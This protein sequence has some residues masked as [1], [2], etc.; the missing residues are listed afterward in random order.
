M[1]SHKWGGFFLFFCYVTIRLK[2]SYF[3]SPP[4]RVTKAYS[5]LSGAYTLV[6]Q[7]SAQ[8]KGTGLK[9]HMDPCRW[10][11]LWARMKPDCRASDFNIT[12]Q[13]KLRNGLEKHNEQYAGQ[14]HK[15]WHAIFTRWLA[16][17]ILYYLARVRIWILRCPDEHTAFFSN[18]SIKGKMA[19]Y[20]L[21]LLCLLRDFHSFGLLQQQP[22]QQISAALWSS[23]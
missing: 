13:K 19:S 14:I 4:T 11:D 20:Q 23:I 8:A 5:W 22:Y 15:A 6:V 9:L 12:W 1:H 18:L 17:I 3:L 16:V 10:I 21:L 7:C 2:R